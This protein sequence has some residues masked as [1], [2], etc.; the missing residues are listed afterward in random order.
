MRPVDAV[1][2][3]EPTFVAGPLGTHIT[4]RGLT[5]YFAGKP[6][7][8]N[9]DLDIPMLRSPTL[10]IADID[11]DGVDDI[12]LGELTDP[13]S[14]VD[15]RIFVSFFSFVALTSRSSARA[16]SPTTMPS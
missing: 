11:G 5:K 16:F 9:F 1:I 6:L 2:E 15:A 8:E 7:Y 13:L 3:A 14:Q 12:V 10:A 4:I